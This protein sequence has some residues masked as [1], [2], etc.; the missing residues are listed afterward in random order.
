M[1]RTIVFIFVALVICCTGRVISQKVCAPPAGDLVLRITSDKL[2]TNVDFEGVY[3]IGDSSSHLIP[4]RATTPYEI[5]VSVKYSYGVFTKISG[6]AK[7]KI[8]LFEIDKGKEHSMVS[9]WADINIFEAMTVGG[10]FKCSVEARDIK[11]K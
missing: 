2:N 7:L 1:K 5:P 11:S 6:D 8:T 9:G 4:V 10:Q 3:I